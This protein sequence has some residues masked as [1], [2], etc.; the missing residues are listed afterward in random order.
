MPA[1]AV[2][3]I[4]DI[5]VPVDD[6]QSCTVVGRNCWVCRSVAW[7]EVSVV[8]RYVILLVIRRWIRHP[9][10]WSR[11]ALGHSSMPAINR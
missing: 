3:D 10:H 1:A 4:V 8:R 5:G 6:R 7:L 2:G 9:L 11:L